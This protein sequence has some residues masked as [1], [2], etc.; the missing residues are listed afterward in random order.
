[1]EI[2]ESSKTMNNT[3]LSA[4]CNGDQVGFVPTMGA[5][6]EGHMALFKK[7]LRENDRLAISCFVN[8]AQ[9]DS[10]SDAEKYP[11][12]FSQD[13]KV[14]EQA[15]V[16]YLFHPSVEEMYP[17]GEATGVISSSPVTRC[18][19]GTIRPNFFDGVTTVVAKLL[20]VIPAH[21]VY[22][23]QKDLQQYIVVRRMIEDLRFPHEIV[24]VTVER[25][26]NGIAYSSRNRKLDSEGW[27]T[28]GQVYELMETIRSE[29]DDLTRQQLFKRY[30][31]QLEEAGL[32]VQYLDVVRF[33]HYDP[34]WP[35][36]RDAVLILAGYI[37]DVRLKDNLPLHVSNVSKLED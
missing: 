31:T 28:A 20:N 21:R 2:F 10:Q 4:R 18:Y 29:A 27:E 3:I 15:G 12:D 11:R 30:V 16:D 6:H 17:P 9:F 1:M 5:L 32:E 35:A 14:A 8:A 25:D 19:E 24:P 36:D 23:G 34:A 13:R 26:E 33:P 22:F 7:A 37:G